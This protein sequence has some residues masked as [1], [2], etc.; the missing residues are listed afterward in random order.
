MEKKILAF[1]AA[2]LML[3]SAAGCGGDDSKKDSNASGGNSSAQQDEKESEQKEDSSDKS[4]SGGGKMEGSGDL[5]DYHVDIKDAILVDDYEGNPAIVVTYA[6]TN[7]SDD[8]TSAMVAL[9]GKA[10]Q[11]GVQ[12]D[13]A[14]VVGQEGY[15]SG[16]S[17][18]EIRP[19]TTIDVQAAFELRNTESVVEFEISELISFSDDVVTMDFDLM[20]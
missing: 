6:W 12:L 16:T 4:E 10:F 11:D 17:M 1:A 15:E 7:N 13:N 5:G 9:H 3:V 18:T 2:A 20:P 19:G 8:T 14:M